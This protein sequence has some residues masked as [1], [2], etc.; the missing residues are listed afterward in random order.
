MR[1]GYHPESE[2]AADKQTLKEQGFYHKPVWR[3][4]RK[5]ALQRDHYLCQLR[6]SPK[7][8]RYATEVHHIKSLE[9]FPD[10]GLSLD[11]LTS[12]CWW[13]HEET[14]HKRKQSVISS[15]VRVI[16]VS[17]GSEM[18]GWSNANGERD[19]S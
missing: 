19:E 11:N 8:T 9:E 16:R 12:C 6:I 3:R 4:L 14:K 17:D 5:M 13:C 1:A 2:K 15:A 18:E 7:C 10:L